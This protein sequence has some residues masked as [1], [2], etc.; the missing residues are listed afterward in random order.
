ML[1]FEGDIHSLIIPLKV[2]LIVTELVGTFE[3]VGLEE[4]LEGLE[5]EGVELEGAELEGA[6]LEGLEFEGLEL[7]GAVQPLNIKLAPGPRGTT[8]GLGLL[9]SSQTGHSP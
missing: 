1:Y 3:E 4:L 7:E 9:Y 8:N 6:E 5:L 2:T